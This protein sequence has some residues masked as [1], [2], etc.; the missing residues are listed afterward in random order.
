MTI[1]DVLELRNVRMPLGD[2]GSLYVLRA[3]AGKWVSVMKQ[4]AYIGSD[5]GFVSMEEWSGRVLTRSVLSPIPASSAERGSEGVS[6]QQ[7]DAGSSEV[8]G[9]SLYSEDASTR[10]VLRLDVEGKLLLPGLVDSHMH[11]DKA[12]SLGRVPNESGTLIEACVNYGA[13]AGSFT[14][15]EIKARMMRAALQALSYGTTYL[16]THL[17]FNTNP[18]IRTAMNTIEAALEVRAELAP[19]LTMQLIP[20]IGYGLST[21]V[22]AAVEESLRMGVDGLGGAPHLSADPKQHMEF[23]FKLAA[24]HGCLVDLH[25]DEN[26]RS[27]SRTVQY[28][29]KLT[30]EYGM[31]GRVT[32]DHLC[33]LASMSDAAAEAVI[34]DMREAGLKAVSLPA[35]NLYLQG[36][37]DNYPV[38]R[39]VTRLKQLWE[40]GIVTAIAS[41]N[42]HDPFHPFGRGDLLQIALISSYAAHMG[43]PADLRT[44]LRMVSTA[45]AEVMGLQGYGVAPGADARF[46][47]VDA[48]SVEELFA[49]QPER[50]WVYSGQQWLRIPAPRA[51]W[52]DS[53]LASL[54][55][56]A[57]E[58]ASFR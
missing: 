1:A 18:S 6:R 29:A 20:M 3:E 55:A 14:K 28:A 10:Q 2:E 48:G 21:E 30:L 46:V 57:S 8:Q 58:R 54:W 26:D 4:A 13:A 56:E 24:K 42:I 11:L 45:P 41:D 37:E 5:D 7:P 19:Y 15:Q 49:M 38:R 32:A 9:S 51:E 31:Q 25:S 23:I 27:D 34:A 43:G 50:R 35:V 47:V 33:S 39:G 12:F 44:L 52:Q 22:L 36:R 53:G 40:A 17:D 16:R